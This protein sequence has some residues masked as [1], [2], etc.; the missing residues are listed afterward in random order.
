M[1][2][3]IHRWGAGIIEFHLDLDGQGDE[4]AAG[5]CWLP[6]QIGKVI[7]EVGKGFVAD[8]NGIKE[9]APSELSDRLWRT[10]PSDGLRPLKSIR[11]TWHPSFE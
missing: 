6:D 10:D 11:D 1:Q 7:A 8:G 4:Y 2:R 3:A 5:H 9:P